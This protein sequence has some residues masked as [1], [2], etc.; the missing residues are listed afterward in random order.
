[1]VTGA[2]LLVEELVGELAHA[3][4][5]GAADDHRPRAVGQ[6]LLERDDL[7]REVGVAREDDVQ[8]LV[9]HDLLP[10]PELLHLELGMHRD[11]HLAA[12]GEDVDGAVVVRTEV[13]PVRRR[14]HRELLDLFAE[15]GDVVARLAERCGQF[16][17]LRHGLGELT[18]GLEQP[19][20]QRP[21]PLRRVLETPSEHDDFLFQPFDAL[22]E[23]IDLSLVLGQSPLVLGSH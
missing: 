3:F 20:F 6:Q 1:M 19:L 10:A 11:A 14:R 21:D 7:A 12:G 9:E 18:F 15:R 2:Q 4:L 16:L 22:L 5:V 13:R 8:R 17:V 23:L